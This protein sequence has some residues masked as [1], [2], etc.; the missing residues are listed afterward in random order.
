MKVLVAQLRPTLQCC[1][2]G[3]SVHAVLH[4]RIL[5]SVAISFFKDL[6][7]PGIELTSLM[8]P[9]LASEFF[10]TSTIWEA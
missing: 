7:N 6:P 10:T 9:A 4:E 5:E 3:S 2:P 8:S 1:P